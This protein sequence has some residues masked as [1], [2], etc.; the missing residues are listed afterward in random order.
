MSFSAETDLASALR[1]F[2]NLHPK[3]IELSLDRIERVLETLGRPQDKLPPV[4]HVAGTN[5]KGSVCAFLRAMG[6]AAGLKVHVFTSP[7]LVRFNERIRLAGK[8]VEDRPIVDWLT[9]IYSAVEGQPI[10][11]FEATTAAAILAFSEVPADLLVLEV[12][13]GGRYDATNVVAHPAVSVITP[14]DIDHKQFLGDTI[15]EIAFEKAGIVKQGRP[16]VSAVQSDDALR[17]IKREA[18]ALAAPLS[19]VSAVDFEHLPEQLSLKGDHQF[20]NAA[21]AA[22]ALKIWGHPAI[23]AQAIHRGAKSAVWPARMQ[24][25]A[26]GPVTAI[27]PNAEVWLDGGHNPH[28]ARAIAALLKDMPGETVLV[29]GMLKS[30]DHEGY[31]RGFE[32]AT[33]HVITCPNTEGHVNASPEDLARAARQAGFSAKPCESFDAA[34]QEA[35]AFGAKRVLIGGSLYLAGQVLTLNQELPQ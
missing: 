29:V 34:M 14:V 4:I 11:H 8:L 23:T 27:A 18:Q 24:K 33:S 13:L 6:E 5:G 35:A 7:H 3:Q 15:A 21:T 25:L 17:V 31:L 16:V 12:G 19:L 2:E 28:A 32:G 22:L 10:T 9:R 26:T 1:R 30:K 20:G